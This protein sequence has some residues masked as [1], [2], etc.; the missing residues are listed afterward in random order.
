MHLKGYQECE[1]EKG[2]KEIKNKNK[3]KSMN[4]T[5]FFLKKLDF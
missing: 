3:N 5:L 2:K 1:R 4:A